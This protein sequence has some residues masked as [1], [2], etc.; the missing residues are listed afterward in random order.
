MNASNQLETPHCRYLWS[1]ALLGVVAHGLLL[2]NDGIF[3]DDW[4]LWLQIFEN[5]WAGFEKFWR[6]LGHRHL[7]PFYD[8]MYSSSTALL[9]QGFLQA[10]S[11]VLMALSLFV[12]YT[13]TLHLPPMAA[14]FAAALA[15]TYPFFWISVHHLTMH[16]VV[17]MGLFCF[18]WALVLNWKAHRAVK[19]PVVILLLGVSMYT[20][21][22]LFAFYF[23]FVALAWYG[24]LV[25]EG[26]LQSPLVSTLLPF[27]RRWWPLLVFPF[28]VYVMK[29]KLSPPGGFNQN[30]NELIFFTKPLGEATQTFFYIMQRNLVGAVRETIRIFRQF[31]GWYWLVFAFFMWGV[32]TLWK[33]RGTEANR[34]TLP[35]NWLN[36]RLALVA[37]VLLTLSIVPYAMVGKGVYSEWGYRHTFLMSIPLG[38]CWVLILTALPRFFPKLPPHF[39]GV[40]LSAFLILFTSGIVY[41]Y[42]TMLVR[43]AVDHA[44]IESLK[45]Q[46]PPAAGTL[47]F[48]ETPLY[49]KRD[50]YRRYE[51][52]GLL[53]R[54][55][56]EL[57][58][59]AVHDRG[60][61]NEAHIE[62]FIKQGR[63]FD[64]KM[65]WQVWGKAP[66]ARPNGCAA[67]MKV[68]PDG[69]GLSPLLGLRYVFTRWFAEEH[70]QEFL[71]PVLKV[72]FQPIPHAGCAGP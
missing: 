49:T 59:Y 54:A 2:V 45:S 52:S 61:R 34:A 7:I 28:V 23:G 53:Y 30:Y 6:D 22:S 60:T 58:W 4:F 56:G 37:A 25:Q 64:D 46:S 63:E 38:L 50:V 69:D 36:T 13:R 10:A 66:E 9:L 11:L 70:M 29:R 68:V 3:L 55:Y 14:W 65:L 44:T 42:N 18:G 43:S 57:K 39:T 67:V 20:Y 40:A 31:P 16:Y 17:S 48:F 71:Q 26:R 62:K 5:D 1:L 47:L 33:R 8:L 24:T 41:K 15:L 21:N 35:Q 72:E 27:A 51:L 19:A 12:I 32:V